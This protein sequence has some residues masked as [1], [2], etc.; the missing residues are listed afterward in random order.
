MA[1][2][3]QSRPGD[4]VC[5]ALGMAKHNI[6]RSQSSD[7]RYSRMLQD[8]AR[9]TITAAAAACADLLVEGLPTQS[10]QGARRTLE[11]QLEAEFTTGYQR[12]REH[13][14]PAGRP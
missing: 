12:V 7:D 3:Q 13:L 5:G 9:A 4:P 6:P 2:H 14:R 11:R 1:T 10:R 8:H